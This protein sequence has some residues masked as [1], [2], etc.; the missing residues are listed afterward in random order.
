MKREQIEDMIK[1]CERQY[2]REVWFRNKLIIE[3]LAY[4]GMR[5]WELAR[6]NV[7]DLRGGISVCEVRENG[8]G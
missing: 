2:N 7:E 4:T 5:I 8:K 3:T 6:L 1:Y